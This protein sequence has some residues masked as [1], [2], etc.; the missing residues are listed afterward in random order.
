[1]QLQINPDIFRAYDIRGLVGD[2]LHPDSVALIARGFA[3]MV[4]D[5]GG[6]KVV[7]GWDARSSSELFAQ[8]FARNLNDCG[9]SVVDIGQV[10]TPLTYFAAHVLEG[11]DGLAM[12]T[13]S[14]NPAAYNGLK[15]GLG[16]LTFQADEIQAL[17]R[18]VEAGDF[19]GGHGT[20]EFVDVF[21][22]YFESV[23]S[24]IEMGKKKLRVVVDAG[25]GVGGLVAQRLYEGLGVD[26]IGMYLEPDGTFPNH[27]A[28]PSQEANVEDL[29]KK[30]LAEKA[31][32]GIA[33]DGDADRLTVIDDRGEILW[34]D[35]LMLLFSRAVLS[36]RPGATVVGEVKCSQVMFDEIRRLGGEPVMWKAGH[37]WIKA[38][39]RETGAALGGEMSGHIFFQ[40]RWFGFDDGPYAGARLLEIL[41]HEDR[42]LSG[43]LADF[44]RTYSSPEVR[45][46]AGSEERK[47]A[48]VREATG[49]FRQQGRDVV[50]VDGARVAF[51]GGWGLVRASNT[52]PIL[53]LR[54]EADS[55][56]GLEAIRK[57]IEDTLNQLER[58]LG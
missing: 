35:Q 22:R 20:T 12:V 34:G 6:S 1:M 37:S 44:P 50:D 38:K 32:L 47:F 15:L 7:L 58:R 9:V 56:E 23:H 14:H 16:Q 31:D 30:V 21:D 13:G 8:V 55:P 40:H 51:P 45:R 46:D 39:M 27:P 24:H 11:I 33:F 25:N 18:I 26:F 10:P 28:D 57:E 29:R 42:P 52:Q 17:R 41:S 4:R 48:L 54:Y 3:K 53:I 2:D 49:F 36:E 19:P 43:L 5:A